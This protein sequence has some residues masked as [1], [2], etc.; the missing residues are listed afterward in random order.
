MGA[1]EQ[2]W[3]RLGKYYDEAVA[4]LE[5]I[6]AWRNE[7]EALADFKKWKEAEM[8]QMQQESRS[9]GEIEEFVKQNPGPESPGPCPE[10]PGIGD[11]HIGVEDWVA[12]CEGKVSLHAIDAYSDIIRVRDQ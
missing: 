2:F 10:E 11:G 3:D 7:T 5:K 8:A 6:W 12:V 1:G 4:H 9:I